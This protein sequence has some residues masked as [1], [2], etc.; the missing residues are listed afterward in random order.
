MSHSNILAKFGERIAARK[1]E[2]D[3][4]FAPL[5][6]NR[7]VQLF[8]KAHEVEPN[9]TGVAVGM[10]TATATGSYTITYEDGEQR[11]E[12]GCYWHSDTRVKVHPSVNAFLAE[13][14]AYSHRLCGGRPDDLPYVSDITLADL[15]PPPRKR[16]K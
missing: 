16:R 3:E 9:L 11:Q 4:E 1:Q 8:R 10:G 13:V 12:R 5:V 7:L 15:P 6:R 14:A 2:I